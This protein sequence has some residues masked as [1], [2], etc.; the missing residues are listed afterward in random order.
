MEIEIQAKSNG[1]HNILG[2]SQL[3]T[4]AGYLALGNTD[5]PQKQ[6]NAT[7]IRFHEVIGPPMEVV[8]R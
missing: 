2:R 3:R 7:T 6:A 1:E 5:P 4:S 8:A